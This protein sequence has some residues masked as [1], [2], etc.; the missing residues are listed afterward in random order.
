MFFFVPQGVPVPPR[1]CRWR[2]DLVEAVG[3]RIE[4]TGVRSARRNFPTAGKS[5]AAE[6]PFSASR[7]HRARR[8]TGRQHARG[9]LPTLF[10]MRAGAPSTA[11]ISCL[12]LGTDV[13][14]A[15]G[16]ARTVQPTMSAICVGAQ[17]G[18]QCGSGSV[19]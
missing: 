6:S 14:R 19:P 16:R 3:L 1:A 5:S 17:T 18:P 11:R 15:L 4:A 9:Q 7:R 12:V 13:P 2:P 10:W 8:P